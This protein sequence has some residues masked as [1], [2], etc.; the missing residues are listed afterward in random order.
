MSRVTQRTSRGSGGSSVVT[1]GLL[2]LPAAMDSTLRVV[3]DYAG[4]DSPL[5][6][7][8]LEAALQY[9]GQTANTAF[10]GFSYINNT[11]ATSGNQQYSP[12][13]TWTGYGWKTDATAASQAVSFRSYVV[14]VQ[15]AANPTG[16]LTFESNINGAGWTANQLTLFS[17]GMVGVN[18]GAAVNNIFFGV[19]T[20][21]SNTN[22]FLAFTNN[23]AATIVA[24]T[25]TGSALTKLQFRGDTIHFVDMTNLVIGSTYGT[26]GNAS[27]MLDV[28]STTKGILIPRMTTTQR[29]A[30]STPATMLIIA[31][32]TT[33]KLNFYN[34]SAW[35]V[36]TSA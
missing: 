23:S 6:L 35:E 17:G 11:A 30:I 28:Q 19:K 15:G 21:N 24:L 9:T 1:T 31:N 14:P 33:N 27:S 5:Y 8:T 10:T 22:G 7:S 26:V 16:Y 3:E 2:K 20:T 29:D 32:T 13:T 36:V 34:G 4:T 18:I 25:D 12:A